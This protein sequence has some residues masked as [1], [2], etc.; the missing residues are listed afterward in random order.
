MWKYFHERDSS[1]KND[2]HSRNDMI[3]AY[4]MNFLNPNRFTFGMPPSR[5][6]SLPASRPSSVGR[7]NETKSVEIVLMPDVAMKKSIVSPVSNPSPSR[8]IGTISMGSST[9]K[10]T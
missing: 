3:P 1:M 2:A 8:A 5:T 9:M 4:R 7:Q 10:A 6:S